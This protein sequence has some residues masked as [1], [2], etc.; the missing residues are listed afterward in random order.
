MKENKYEY[1][2][3]VQGK[4]GSTYGWEDLCMSESRKEARHDLTAYCENE[5][6]YPH[7]LIHRRE[8]KEAAQ[9]KGESR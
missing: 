9:A 8:K 7:R 2:Y 1:L 4:Y 5:P 3:V 6:R